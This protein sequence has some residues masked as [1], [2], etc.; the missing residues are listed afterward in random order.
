MSN[1]SRYVKVVQKFKLLKLF[2][3]AIVFFYEFSVF[4]LSVPY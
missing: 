3:S 4:F 2:M 1:F